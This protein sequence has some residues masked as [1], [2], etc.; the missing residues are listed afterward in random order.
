MG[1]RI[2]VDVGSHEAREKASQKLA[3]S[4]TIV[5]PFPVLLGA[6]GH[7]WACSFFHCPVEIASVDPA[8]ANV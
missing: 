8:D 2:A 5:K 4:I 7:G 1:K 6:C 3:L